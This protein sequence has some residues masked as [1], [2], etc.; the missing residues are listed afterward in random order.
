MPGVLILFCKSNI[1]IALSIIIISDIPV[2]SDEYVKSKL[3][4]AIG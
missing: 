1:E 4:R 3:K 2:N